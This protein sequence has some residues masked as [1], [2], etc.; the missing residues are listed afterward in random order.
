MPYKRKPSKSYKKKSYSKMK[1]LKKTVNKLIN[2]KIETKRFFT[3]PYTEQTLTSTQLA[4]SPFA[5]YTPTVGNG[6]ENR[7]GEITKGIGLH[8]RYVL[9]N[10]SA[11]PVYVRVVVFDDVRGE[12]TSDASN[13]IL[14]ATGQPTDLTADTLQDIYAP[15]NKRECT[16]LYD[17][18]HR[19]AGLG[20]GT[21][22][23]TISRK[24]LLKF[25]HKNVFV[26]ST[27]NSKHTLR[28][29]FWV[30]SADN[31][32]TGATIEMTMATTYYFKDA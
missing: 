14:D 31:D 12:L 18:V 2:S 25:N 24:K 7:I 4:S 13:F 17:K 8:M 9:H 23:E 21:G 10:N 6:I 32:T 16:L 1:G 22:I 28:V 15:F 30:R 3:A 26:S 29:C 20:D 27:T 11:V 5:V 19:I